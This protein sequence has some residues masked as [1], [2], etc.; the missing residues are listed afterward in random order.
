M[1][2]TIN[3]RPFYKN[4]PILTTAKL[5]DV[6]GVSEAQLLLLTANSSQLYRL[7]KQEKKE[8]GSIR[9]TYDAFTELKSVQQRIKSRILSRAYYP[10]Y[11]QGSLKSDT[12]ERGYVANAKLHS[13]ARIIISED[14]ANFFP[15]IRSELVYLMW[16]GLFRFSNEVSA[17]LTG[18]TT[19]DGCVP[20]GAK[21]SSYI[22]NLIFWGSEW[23]LV[24]Y[25]S[26]RGLKYT[27]YVDDITISSKSDL[28]GK[29]IS[30]AIRR[31]YGM[32]KKYGL[33]PKRSKHAVYLSGDRMVVNKLVVNVRPNLTSGKRSSLRSAV[34]ECELL[35]LKDRTS[36]NFIS[37]YRSACV[38]VGQLK[39]LD[40]NEAKRLKARLNQIASR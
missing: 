2:R 4:G 9:Q 8:D 7:A 3:N 22:A 36:E 11:L 1:N 34:R 14:I 15:S 10:P 29:T 28:S 30:E 19:K 33:R 24:D 27:R 35:S 13:A 25:L 32:L 21:T 31:L 26:R 5:A 6:L 39:R 37:S 17:C 23:R 20:Q 12:V 38:R 16:S 18:L 40:A